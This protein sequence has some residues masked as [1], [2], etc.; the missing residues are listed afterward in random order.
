MVGD[1]GGVLGR[2]GVWRFKRGVLRADP[3]RVG[4]RTFVVIGLAAWAGWLLV[5]GLINRT[6]PWIGLAMLVVPLVWLLVTERQWIDSE[7]E[8]SAV[9]RTIAPASA[10]VHC[11]R[12]GERITYLGSDLGHVEFDADG[13]PAGPAYLTYDVCRDLSS[14]WH[15]GF[16]AKNHPTT[17]QAIAVHVL[18]H[19]S[20]HLTGI[21]SESMA[22]CFA[23]QQD[24]KTAE[25]L[26]ANPQQAYL[27]AL[28]YW[29]L[30]YPNM[31]S[32]YTTP[33]CAP[34][35]KLDRNPGDTVWP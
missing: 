35:G 14:Y 27:V 13:Q 2:R 29:T 1:G 34:G 18:S 3:L 24:T 33:D 12:W 10:G 7:H 31:P 16:T 23:V 19:E 4:I 6:M 20:E 21:E 5:R 26:G 8:F 11:Q 22:E 25:E 28:R 32:D 15:A 30:I 17:E 9:A